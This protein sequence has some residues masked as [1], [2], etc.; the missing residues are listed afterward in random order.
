MAKKALGVLLCLMFLA[1]LFIIGGCGSEQPPA[2]NGSA[3]EAAA[4]N[5]NREQQKLLL[6]VAAGMKK[7]MDAVIAKFEE[8]TGHKVVPNYAAS[9]GLWAQ[10]KQGQPCDLYYSADWMYIEMAEEEGRL[11]ES[12]EFLRDDLVLVVSPSAKDKVKTVEDLTKSGISCV[13]GEPKAPYGA[14]GEQA[15]KNMGLWDDVQSTLKAR[16]STVNQA[17]I[18]IKEDQ[19]DAGLIYNSVAN[20]NGLDQVQVID[21]EVTGEIIFGVGVI[22]G[23]NEDLAKQF[24]DFACQH[25]DEFTHYGWRPYA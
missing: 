10:I 4:P 21:Q 9:G 23:G 13:V 16:P 25:V 15:L 14:Y 20:G 17:A 11:T 24:M 8:E 5:E 18:M 1:A 7:P 19:V 2:G 22:K 3:P 12:K 6:Y